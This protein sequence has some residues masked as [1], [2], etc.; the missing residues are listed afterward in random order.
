MSA[1]NTVAVLITKARKG[2][3][4]EVRVA[5][6]QALEN[7]KYE[8]DY[9]SGKYRVLNRR[10]VRALFARARIFFNDVEAAWSY[11]ESVEREVG[12]V[13]YGVEQFDFSNIYFPASD[14]K[15]SRRYMQRPR[16]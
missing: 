2:D 13:E 14:R 7:I 8:P 9:P 16:R 4:V 15:R 1:D 6:V 11:A 10:W 5:H 3:G 12:Y